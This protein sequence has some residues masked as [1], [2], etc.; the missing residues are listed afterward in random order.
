MGICNRRTTQS[1]GMHRRSNAAG[2]FPWTFPTGCY[3]CWGVAQLCIKRVHVAVDAP[4]AVWVRPSW[5]R[6]RCGTCS[7]GDR[8]MTGDRCGSGF[9]S[10]RAEH[11]CGCCSTGRLGDGGPGRELSEALRARVPHARV[12]FDRFHVER[13]ATDAVDEVRRAEQRRVGAKAANLRRFSESLCRG[14]WP[15]C[16]P[17]GSNEPDEYPAACT[18][19]SRVSPSG[20]RSHAIGPSAPKRSDDR[21]PLHGRRLSRKAALL[22]ARYCLA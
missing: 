12:V 5:R 17:P 18:P 6:P 8:G 13:L 14:T 10:R 1:G 20:C 3:G 21:F 7:L 16:V 19:R 9:T 4:L 11:R 22:F 15:P 2:T